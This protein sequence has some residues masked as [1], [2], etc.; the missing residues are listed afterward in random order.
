M[1]M[2]T[3]KAHF[4]QDV[5]CLHKGVVRLGSIL[6]PNTSVDLSSRRQNNSRL[7]ELSNKVSALRGVTINIYDNARNQEVIDSSVRGQA[8]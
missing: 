8:M 6:Y 1:L 7:D 2:S 5:G 3:C 4:Q